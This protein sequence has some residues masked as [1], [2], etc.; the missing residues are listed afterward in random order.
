[1][2]Q[3]K[4]VFIVALALCFVQCNT[5]DKKE[6]KGFKYEHKK[7]EQK[8][9]KEEKEAVIVPVDLN[10]KGIGPVTALTF[11]AGIDTGLAEKGKAIYMEKCTACHMATKKL[12]GPALK[13]VY[14]VRSP[15][16]VMNMIINPIEMLKKD[17]IAK[18][19]QEECNGA[20][21]IDQRISQEDARSIA[22]YLRTL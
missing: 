5:P 8:S 19:L 3:L 15:E 9:K 16:W 17:P 14:D 22:E 2:S 21:M 4:Y 11:P 6:K 10:N 18:A 12:V 13:G 1:M 20:V 7:Q